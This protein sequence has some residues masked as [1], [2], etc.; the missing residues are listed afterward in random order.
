MT[1]RMLLAIFLVSFIAP[2][3]GVFLPASA[4][5]RDGAPAF[6]AVT[7]P[8]PTGH[9]SQALPT[10]PAAVSEAP[11][12]RSTAPA[13]EPV[14]KETVEADVSSRSVAITSG[15]TGL[16]LVVFGTVTPSRQ[17]SAE[18]GYY[19]VVIVLEGAP[20]PL[21]ARRKTEVG[22]IWI[23]TQSL[24]FESVPSYYAI[25]SSRPL[26]EIANPNILSE[27]D[28]GFEHVRMMPVK[29]WETGLTTAD[30]ADFKSAVI[31]VK[32][33]D[34]LYIHADYGVTFTGRALFRAKVELP[35]NIPVGPLISRVYLFHNGQLLSSFTR[36]VTLTREGL[37]RIVYDFAI[38]APYAYALVTVLI[39]AI[40]GLAG[41]AIFSR[42][43]G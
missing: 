38:G 26:D 15:F 35:A 10:A 4:V 19:D 1:L 20:A 41:S 11:A 17:P 23:N 42:E 12:E 24:T 37:E 29:G 5:S 22:G 43:R 18:S 6:P 2:V 25:A 36:R 31:R 9:I 40:V 34:G 16:E 8:R 13:V 7:L 30:L 3:A 32:Q 33:R 39:A 27:N 28:I 14:Q 21:V